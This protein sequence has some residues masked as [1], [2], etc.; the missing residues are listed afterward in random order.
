MAV[1]AMIGVAAGAWL[2]D[3]IDK[4]AARARSSAG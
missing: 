3:I 4:D 1:P 2:F